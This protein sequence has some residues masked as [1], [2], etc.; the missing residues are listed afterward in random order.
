MDVTYLSNTSKT[1]PMQISC[2]T[3]AMQLK[4][5][6]ELRSKIL[7]YCLIAVPDFNL[8]IVTS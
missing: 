7:E 2:D 4:D 1:L 8:L 5:Y 6:E 3:V